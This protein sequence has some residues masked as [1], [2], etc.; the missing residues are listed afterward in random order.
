[1]FCTETMVEGKTIETH[2]SVML[3]VGRNLKVR[4]T[5]YEPPL[6]ND[7]TIGW[8]VHVSTHQVIRP[9]SMPMS[10]PSVRSARTPH[11]SS[12]SSATV[13]VRAINLYSWA[14]LCCMWE[15]CAKCR[16]LILPLP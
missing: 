2:P 7:D 1:M 8:A 12:A 4:V 10:R 13:N 15:G 5:S 11:T 16:A 9:G 6:V 14:G 3:V